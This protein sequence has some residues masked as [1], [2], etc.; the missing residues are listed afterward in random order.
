[1]IVCVPHPVNRVAD[2][3]RDGVRVEREIDDVDGNRGQERAVL[4]R[5]NLWRK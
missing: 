2:L 4:Q 3:D 5:L 1:M